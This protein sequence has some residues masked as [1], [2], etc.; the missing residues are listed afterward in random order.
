MKELY[1]KNLRDLHIKTGNGESIPQQDYSCEAEGVNIQVFFNNHKA[2]ILKYIDKY[3]SVIG[4][5]SWL[6][7]FD[8]LRA[9]TKKKFV[10][11]IVQKGNFL[12][13]FHNTQSSH[14]QETK[15]LYK[16]LPSSDR[17]LLPFFVPN[18]SLGWLYQCDD[19]KRTESK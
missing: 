10:S 4:C 12:R 13:P 15:E 19:E 16:M 6:I 9:L 7:D 17:R 3:N 11:I 1:I 8:V 14:F 5:I 2:Q 18:L